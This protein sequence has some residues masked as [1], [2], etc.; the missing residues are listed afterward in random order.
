[1]RPVLENGASMIELLVGMVGS[2]KS[3]YARKRAE[4]GWFIVCHDDI[5]RMVHGRNYYW[6]N[7]SPIYRAIEES[8]VRSAHGYCLDVVVDRTSLR[9]HE[10]ERW[11]KIAKD[12]EDKIDAVVFPFEHHEIHA[13][14]RFDDD[15]RGS[16]LEAWTSVTRTHG[17][18]A[19]VPDE[20][21]GFRK[22]VYPSGKPDP[23][24]YSYITV[25]NAKEIYA[26]YRASISDAVRNA[27]SSGRKP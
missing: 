6:S 22:I 27:N 2:G 19:S 9:R 21:E 13:Q 20:S 5:V 23:S 12:L 11:I 14:R 8:A 16:S 3:T 24:F 26:A 25:E 4:E 1:M 17:M 10:R 15:P 7:F 18:N